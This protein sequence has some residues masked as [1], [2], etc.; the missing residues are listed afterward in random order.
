MTKNNRSNNLDGDSTLYMR[1]IKWENA[2]IC[3]CDMENKTSVTN[4]ETTKHM[5]RNNETTKNDTTP[6][7]LTYRCLTKPNLT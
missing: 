6:N 1:V 3:D 5:T 2:L 7:N 4:V